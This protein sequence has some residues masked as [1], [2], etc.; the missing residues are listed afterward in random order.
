MPRLTSF[1]LQLAI[2]AAVAA[3]VF[4]SLHF[5]AAPYGR[6]TRGGWGPAVPNRLGWIVMEGV[7]AVAILVFYLR[8]GPQITPA[9][10]LLLVL[11]EMHYINRAF[12]YPLRLRTRGK[13][14]PVTVMM[15][16]M[17]YN[18]WN[19]YLNG[20]WLGE[21]AEA[22][23]NEWMFRPAFVAGLAIFAA[24]FALNVWSD[25]IL[26]RLRPGEETGYAIPRGGP[27][28]FVSC[29]NY[30]GEL[31]EW[32]GWALMAWS[33]AGLVFV[34]WTAAN[35]VPRARSHHR[36]YREQF[37]D[38]PAGRKAILPFVY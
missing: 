1:E 17:A 5:T 13:R 36:W 3:G 19:G 16:A 29:P 12:V 34:V 26:L 7:A 25:E 20:R 2:S 30:L 14:M 37:A 23:T 10:V 24:G 35:L 6:H 18:M 38:Y 11:W 33:P 8:E 32:S 4:V 28:R 9:I 22:Y 27:F 21:H 31:I 15:M